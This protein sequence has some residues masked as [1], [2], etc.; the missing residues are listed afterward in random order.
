MLLVLHILVAVAGIV[1][2]SAA[3]V[4]PSQQ[5]LRATNA[6][7]VA[8]LTSGTVLVWALESPLMQ[9]CMT[10]LAYLAFVLTA[11]ALARYRLAKQLVRLR[12]K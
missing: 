8:T 7:T 9:S 3:F 11:T 4:W 1:L 12:D 6:L 5:K 2:A 10:G